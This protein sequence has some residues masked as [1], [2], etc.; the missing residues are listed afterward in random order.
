MR[1]LI[2]L[3]FLFMALAACVSQPAPPVVTNAPKPRVLGTVEVS[4]DTSAK[5]AQAKVTRGLR[6]QGVL[7]DNVASFVPTAFTDLADANNR[8]LTADFAVTNLSATDFKNLTLYAYAQGSNSVGGTAIKSIVS[9]GGNALNASAVQ[10]ARPTHGTTS[11]AGTITVD[12]NR[13]DFQ[14]FSSTEAQ[15]VQTAALGGTLTSADTVLEYGYV[16]RKGSARLIPA[17]NGTGTVTLGLQVPL[18]AGAG[19]P[20]KFALTFVLADEANPRVTRGAYPPESTLAVAARAATITPAAPLPVPEVVLLGSDAEVTTGSLRLANAKISTLPSFLL[21]PSCAT[22]AANTIMQ[23]QGSGAT[24]NTAIPTPTVE[25]VVTGDFQGASNLKGFYIQDRYGDGDPSTSDGIFVFENAATP[26]NVSVG[27]YV[28]VTGTAGEFT[29]TG[30]SQTQITNPTAITVCGT[31]ALPEAQTVTFPVANVSDL[32][33]FEGMRIKIPTQLTVTE[34]FQ[35]GRFGQVLL[36]SGGSSNLTG[37]DDRLESYTQFNTPDVTGNTNYLADI[38]KRRIFV[39]DGSGVSNPDPI[40]LGRGGNPLSASNTL[41]GGDTIQN[42]TGVLDQTFGD[43]RVQP[44][45]TTNFVAANPRPPAPAFPAATTLRASSFN[46]LNFFTTLDAGGAT[47]TPTGC[48]NTIAPRGA[49][50]AEEFTRQKDKI[51][52]AI[53]GLNVD[54]LGITEMQNNGSGTVGAIAD[55]VAALNTLAGAG[56]YAAAPAPT[57]GYGCDAIKVDFIYKPAK[58]NLLSV[59]SPDNSYLSFGSGV[60]ASGRKPV[61]ATF[62]QIS[63]NA[64]FTAVINHFKSKGSSAG[65]TGDTDTGDGQGNSNGTRVRNATDLLNWLTTTPPSTDPDYLLMGDFNAYSK[66][67]PITTIEAGGYTNLNPTTS[68][69]YVFNGFWASLDHALASTSLNTQ[70]TGSNEWHIN[71]DEPTALDYNTEFKSAGQVTSLY[72]NQP[73]RSSDH[74]PVVIGLN[75]TAGPATPDFSL[76]A[77]APTG[78]TTAGGSSTSTVTINRTNLPDPVTLSLNSNAA[79]ITGSFAPSNTTGTSSSLTLTV[80]ALTAGSYLVTITGVSGALTKTT[81]ANVVVSQPCTVSSVGITGGTSVTVGGTLNLTGTVTSSPSGCDTAGVTWTVAPGT[82]TATVSSSG[83]VT[84]GTAG[85]VTVT[86]TSITNSSVSGNVSITVTAPAPAAVVIAEVYGGNGVTYKNDYVVL[87]NRSNALVSL[88]GL[89]IQYASATGT[90]NFSLAATLTGN[91]AAGRYYLVQLASSATG[92]DLPAADA[93]GT[94]NISST[95]GKVILANATTGLACNGGS[96]ACTP[97]QTAQILDLVGYGLA[98]YFEGSAAAPLLTT[99]TAATRAGSG[100]QDTNV[101]S[102]DFT[103]ALPTPRNTSSPTVTCP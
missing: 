59:V 33:R 17:N 49:N 41:R 37:T 86:A 61:A 94:T 57:N 24:Y 83:V 40:K 8:Y 84:G 31:R 48:T 35:L 39:D 27:D 80:P 67:A 16:A 20:Y 42:L 73:F 95:S 45:E 101:N 54:V 71:A 21:E 96:T 34:H 6:T 75:L 32:E 89:S 69:S 85:T 13:A 90:G 72:S 98:N 78:V 65:G 47:F 51:A 44:T 38:A 22:P 25:G 77:T 56:T 43:Y 62:Q 7:A 29:S 103:A 97:S 4:F 50:T 81:T 92:A 14:A 76:S 82:G 52:N 28:Q 58:V 66:E 11:N 91:L 36:S 15:A 79:G 99:V 19:T 87:F 88:S 60:G 55:L 64:V 74:D 18:G 3:S 93:T 53:N 5:T 102:A 9:F 12:P 10:Q 1:R 30:V 2:P 26:A 100:C 68:Y 70:V 23:V 63:N 46:V